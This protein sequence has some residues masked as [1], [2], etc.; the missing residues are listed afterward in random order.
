MP[1]QCVI[2][3][4]AVTFGDDGWPDEIIINV[5]CSDFVVR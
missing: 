5:P 4:S 2:R 3:S 1:S